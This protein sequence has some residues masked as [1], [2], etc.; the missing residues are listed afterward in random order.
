MVAKHPRGESTTKEG[1]LF[2]QS[3]NEVLVTES[4][5]ACCLGLRASLV[6]EAADKPPRNPLN[7]RTPYPVALIILPIGFWTEDLAAANALDLSLE[8]T[9]FTLLTSWLPRDALGVFPGSAR[10]SHNGVVCAR[11]GFLLNDLFCPTTASRFCSCLGI[12]ICQDGKPP[13]P[14]PPP[15]SQD[16]VAEGREAK[17]GRHS[18]ANLALPAETHLKA[19]ASPMSTSVP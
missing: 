8:V 10:N 5:L 11:S 18:S 7:D 3:R 13:P 14:P 15:A 12:V 1:L 19:V 2:R 9:A 4:I 6:G 17:R 16:K